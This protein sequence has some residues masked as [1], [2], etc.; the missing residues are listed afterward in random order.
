MSPLLGCLT[1]ASIPS[2]LL[3]ASVAVLL[4]S[5]GGLITLSRAAAQ[6]RREQSDARLAGRASADHGPSILTHHDALTGLSTRRLFRDRLEQSLALAD[7]EGKGVA[8]LCIDL[9]RFRVLNELVGHAAADQLLIAVGNRLVATARDSD[10]VARLGGDEFA[11]VQPLGGTPREAWAMA[12]RLLAALDEPFLVDGQM[13]DIGASIGIALHPADGG[14]AEFLIKNAEAALHR[15]KHDGRGCV[16]FFEPQTNLHLQ[17]RRALEHDLHHALRRH[18]LVLNYQPL[19]DSRSLCVIGYE[20]LLR[21][22]HPTRGTVPPAEFI[23]LAEDCGLIGLIGEWVLRTAC[24]EA[25]RWPLPLRMAV[26]LSPLQFRERDLPSVVAGILA[27]TGLAASRLELEVTEG[28]LIGDT[29]R[30]LDILRGLK[31]QG[32]RIA[33]DDFGTGYFSLSY[34]RRFPF[35]KLKID[36]SFVRELGE[37]RETDAIV[38]SIL[39]LCRSLS[40]DV[41]AEGVETP[42]QLALLREQKCSQV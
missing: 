35:D 11:V 31:A 22:R 12:Q 40:L 3:T 39:A 16:C 2:L 34:L 29:A 23:P 8:L 9:D 21:W 27:E 25:A 38:S 41:T 15:A 7:R 6:L 20:A 28:V 18:E 4:A 14:S 19:F 24:A 13:I 1:D 37:D 17:A 10:T 36:R 32:I 30:A 5:F 26:N 42:E 33:L